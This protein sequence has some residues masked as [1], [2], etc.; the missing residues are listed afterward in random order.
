MTDAKVPSISDVSCVRLVRLH[1]VI[2]YQCHIEP[3]IMLL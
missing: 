2:N 3:G 1:G